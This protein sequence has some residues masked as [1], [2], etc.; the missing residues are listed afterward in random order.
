MGDFGSKQFVRLAI[1]FRPLTDILIHGT[2]R[3]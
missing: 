1:R 2:G 3:I